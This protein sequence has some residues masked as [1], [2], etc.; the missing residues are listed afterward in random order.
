MNKPTL[1][2][3][4]CG[5]LGRQMAYMLAHKHLIASL[6]IC[7]NNKKSSCNSIQAIGYGQA[8]G[9]INEL[10]QA[11]VYWLAV[12]DQQISTVIDQLLVQNPPRVNS[13]I[14]HSSGALPASIMNAARSQQCRLASL[15]PMKSFST[16]S[17][18]DNA[19][20]GVFCALEGDNEALTDIQ[21]WLTPLEL[22][23]L[24]I[25]SQ[26][27]TAYHAAGVF[28]SNYLISVAEAANQQLQQAGLE[29]ALAIKVITQLM[30]NTLNNLSN[31]GCLK[32]SL[33]GPLQRGDIDT[34]ERHLEQLSSLEQKQLYA[35]LGRNIIELTHH[36]EDFKSQINALLLGYC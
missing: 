8:V 18:N 2:W 25:D 5:K 20:K 14:I 24:N 27:K 23:W 17:K 33:T 3:I 1:N 29:P 16:L 26:H 21:Q 22:H 31:S 4:G 35:N 7:N 28:A 6:T 11:D 13:L 30:Q 32:A 10:P 36:N 9:H 19:L 12:P 34:I 15:H